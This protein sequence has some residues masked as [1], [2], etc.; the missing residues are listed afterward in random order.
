MSQRHRL[1]RSVTR[2]RSAGVLYSGAAGESART[3][4][5]CRSLPQRRAWSAPQRRAASP[6]GR[7]FTSTIVL[8]IA[9]LLVDGPAPAPTGRRRSG[10][11]G[12]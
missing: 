1:L 7:S 5:T 9:D 8:R 11:T 6:S 12:G 10:F 3:S 2:S 4:T